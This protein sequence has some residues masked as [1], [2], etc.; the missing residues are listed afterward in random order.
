MSTPTFVQC[1]GSGDQGELLPIGTVMCPVCN[2]Q[3]LAEIIAQ[4]PTHRRRDDN[5]YLADTRIRNQY[6]PANSQENRP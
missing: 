4:L 2:G 1:E 5:E 3:L 6:Q